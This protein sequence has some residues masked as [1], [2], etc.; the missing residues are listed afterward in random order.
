M[1][2]YKVYNLNDWEGYQD[3]VFAETAKEAK[4]KGFK[5]SNLLYDSDW[6]DIRVNRLP[7][8]DG[9]ENR[10]KKEIMYVAIL[11]GWWYE[12]DGIRYH[13]ENIGEAI[14]KGIV[15]PYEMGVENER[16]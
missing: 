3:I 10:D 8:L 14:N 2:A 5:T 9:M 11:N 12:I 16:N 15:T 13:E 4:K 6:I 7:F 1:K